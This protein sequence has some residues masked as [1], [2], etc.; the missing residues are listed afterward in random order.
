MSIPTLLVF[1]NGE[2]VERIVGFMPK[3]KL[4]AKI[5]PHL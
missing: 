5:E 3:A 4:L 2:P 1:K